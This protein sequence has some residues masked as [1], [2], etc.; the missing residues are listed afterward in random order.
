M[1]VPPRLPD[2]AECNGVIVHRLITPRGESITHLDDREMG[3]AI[4]AWH[5]GEVGRAVGVVVWFVQRLA[6]CADVAIQLERNPR[7]W[8]RCDLNGRID[9]DTCERFDQRQFGAE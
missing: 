1:C 3:R 5:D 4:S 6:D 7:T 2:F 9:A 8:S